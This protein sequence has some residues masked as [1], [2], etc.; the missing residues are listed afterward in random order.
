MDKGSKQADQLQ[1]FESLK[2]A[3]GPILTRVRLGKAMS[4][5]FGETAWTI[6]ANRSVASRLQQALK[7]WREGASRA[8]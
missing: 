7:R 1:V 6:Q 5:L 4:E 3:T 2:P 8:W